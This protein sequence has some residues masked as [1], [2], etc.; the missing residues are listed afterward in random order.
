[1]TLS[2]A[3]TFTAFRR[4]D[5]AGALAGFVFVR[6]ASPQRF[7]VLTSLFSR[8]AGGDHSLALKTNGTVIGRGDPFYGRSDVPWGLSNVG[9]ILNSR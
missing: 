5:R 6:P 3:R 1:M 7:A 2:P 4:E 9:A 8:A